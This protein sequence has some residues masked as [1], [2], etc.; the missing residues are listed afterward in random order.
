MPAP[1]SKD[2][3]DTF[4]PKRSQISGSAMQGETAA[5]HGGEAPSKEQETS[6]CWTG[7]HRAYPF[8]STRSISLQCPMGGKSAPRV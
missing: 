6:T 5:T 4:I 1:R 2:D 7:G 3:P 8:G